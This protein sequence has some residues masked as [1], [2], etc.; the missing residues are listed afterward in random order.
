MRLLATTA[1]VLVL[2]TAG[3]IAADAPELIIDEP[4]IEMA[5]DW[6]GVYIG[7]GVQYTAFYGP[8]FVNEGSANVVLGFNAQADM[9]LFGAEAFLGGFAND[10]PDAGW[11]VG[12]E[13]RAGVLV[14]PEV[15]FYGALGV[16]HRES[17]GPGRTYAT[18]GG[19][20]EFMVADNVT[21]DLEYKHYF[22]IVSAYNGDQIGIS[23]NWLFN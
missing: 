12:A 23:I 4:A 5:T 19:G 2:G 3:A 22:P 7:A 17:F 16:V 14:T 8:V 1:I 13:G 20:I 9:V 15:L 10:F 21:I 6:T 11:W 18:L